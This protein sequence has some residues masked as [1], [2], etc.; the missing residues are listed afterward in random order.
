M[1]G[2]EVVG[3]P[4]GAPYF[5]LVKGKFLDSNHQQDL[6]V[7]FNQRPIFNFRIDFAKLHTVVKIQRFSKKFIK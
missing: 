3:Y 7:A 6:Y 2:V 1:A 4:N 5:L